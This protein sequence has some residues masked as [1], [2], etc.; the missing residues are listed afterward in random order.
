MDGDIFVDILDKARVFS[1]KTY[2]LD[3]SPTNIQIPKGFTIHGW[4][5]LS[6]TLRKSTKLQNVTHL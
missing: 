1:L 5:K 3:M 4:P 2:F 6:I